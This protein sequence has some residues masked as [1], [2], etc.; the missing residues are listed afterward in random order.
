MTIQIL[1]TILVLGFSAIPSFAD[2]NATH[3]TNPHWT[4]HARFHCVW[5]VVSYILIGLMSLYLIWNG[6]GLGKSALVLVFAL[7]TIIYTGFFT[8]ALTR[9]MYGGKLYDENGYL[10]FKGPFGGM[11]DVNVTIFTTMALLLA[12]TAY[13]LFGAA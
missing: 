2:F 9:P 3:A 5:Q 7:A 6:A 10:P 1:L 11:W 8:A 4:G 13:L 12:V